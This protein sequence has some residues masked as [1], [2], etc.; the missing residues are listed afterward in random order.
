MSIFAI[1][2]SH[3][4]FFHNSTVIKE[5]WVSFANLPLTWF[6]LCKEG[7]DIYNIGTRLGNGHEKKNIKSGDNVMFCYGWNDIQKNIYKYSK[8]SYEAELTKMIDN[9]GSLLKKYEKQFNITPIIQ[10]IMPNPIKESDSVSGPANVRDK[11]IKFANT[12]LT[13]YCKKHDIL[14][15]NVYNIVSD[16]NGYL[17]SEF[18][19]DGIHLDYDN[20]YLRETIDN[21]LVSLINHCN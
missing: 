5:H 17:K 15:L 3:S 6:R 4:I 11:Y 7:L 12:Y 1:G 16:D 10:N 21:K 8:D 20:K 9:Y 2:D 14:F 18:T 19:K 13:E